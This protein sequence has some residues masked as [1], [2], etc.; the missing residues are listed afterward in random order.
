MLQKVQKYIDELHMVSQGDSILVGVSGGADSVCLLLVLCALY[1]DAQ[2]SLEVV[3]VEHGIR[4]AESRQDAAF[5]EKLCKSL[6][7][8]CH[9]V[10]VDVPSYARENGLGDEEAARILR[11]EA[12]MR[13]A[14]ERGAKIALAHHMED[15]AE[16][17]LFQLARGSVLAGLCGMQPVRVD[18]KGVCYIRPLLEIRR[19]EIE[20]FLMEQGQVYCIDSTNLELDYSRNYIRSKVLPEL[21]KINTQAISHINET[22]EHLTEVK[23]FLDAE[24]SAHWIECVEQCEDKICLQISKWTKLHKFLKK[25]L[26]YRVIAEAAGSKKDIHAVHVEAVMSLCEGQSGKEVSLPYGLCAKKEYDRLIVYKNKTNA[27]EDEMDSLIYVTEAELESCFKSRQALKKK[28]G[29]EGDI[30]Q[31]RMISDVADFTEIP[32][33]PYT[34]WMDYDKI[35]QGFCIRNRKSGDYFICDESGHRK[36]LKQ[37]FIDEKIAAS[38][39]ENMWMLAQENLVLW[40]IGG[41]ISE[42]VKITEN[43]K[44][45]VEISYQ[46]GK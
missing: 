43:T 16:T 4:G 5:V 10:E 27:K 8:P 26:V 12:F 28:V 37:Y 34:K 14:K 20:S 23:D 6:Q 30:I 46:G 15:N 3:H 32:K 35:K 7:L 21:T 24:A 18:E 11:Y 44:T 38:Q 13:L 9:V 2:V 39:R 29:K 31:I 22:A 1:K 33:N 19:S 45:I 40:L 25:E 41:R 36:K 17:I 42:H